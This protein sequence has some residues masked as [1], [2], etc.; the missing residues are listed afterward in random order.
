MGLACPMSPHGQRTTPQGIV[1]S[2]SIFFLISG[3]MVL[4]T[5]TALESSDTS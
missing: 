1:S 4:P 2:I 3:F 5:A